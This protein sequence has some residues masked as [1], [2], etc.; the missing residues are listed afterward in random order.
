MCRKPPCTRVAAVW[1]GGGVA[2]ESE[3]RGLVPRVFGRTRVARGGARDAEQAQAREDP[4][5]ENNSDGQRS[6]R[7]PGPELVRLGP[8]CF[9]VG[10]NLSSKP[11]TAARGVPMVVAT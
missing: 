6:A 2:A 7:R 3:S 1:R 8:C 10:S 4:H 11:L 9:G 5:R